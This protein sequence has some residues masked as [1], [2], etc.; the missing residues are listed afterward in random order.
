MIEKIVWH[1]F[2]LLVPF[3]RN[4]KKHQIPNW[5]SALAVLAVVVVSE[6][7]AAKWQSS[8]SSAEKNQFY[9]ESLVYQTPDT[10]S[11]SVQNL[12]L[13]EQQVGYLTFDRG[14]RLAILDRHNS[15]GME[16]L[17]LQYDGNS[18]RFFFDLFNH[19]PERCMASTGAEVTE[20]YRS[21]HYLLDGQDYL[22]QSLKIADPDSTADR[23]VFKA[24]WIHPDHPV[25]YDS[26]IHL[27]RIKAAL[28]TVPPPPAMLMMAGLYGF[29]SRTDAEAYFREHALDRLRSMP[30]EIASEGTPYR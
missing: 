30:I 17:Y 16:L 8:S 7:V 12:P 20:R 2:R 18:P 5:S 9:R 29:K 1:G 15:R 4:M 25:D 6:S 24:I 13:E 26:A 10:P 14:R 3:V 27:K 21:E 28:A 19:P 23:F 22:V 11:I